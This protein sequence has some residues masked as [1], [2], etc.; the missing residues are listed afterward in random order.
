MENPEVNRRIAQVETMPEIKEEC[1]SPPAEKIYVAVGK[2]LDQ[3]QKA[4][5]FLLHIRPALRY[6]PSPIG[7]I[8]LNQARKDALEAYRKDE[9]KEINL[10]MNKYL[11]MCTIAKVKAGHLIIEREEVC[12]G[13]VEVV[14][15]RG[16][17]RL[18]PAA[19]FLS[20]RNNFI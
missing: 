9:E 2:D 12:K 19:P 8:P 17:T 18:Q 3:R 6:F 16:I 1:A 15:E 13:I 5:I 20:L 14:S 4:L 7:K 11:D 10:C